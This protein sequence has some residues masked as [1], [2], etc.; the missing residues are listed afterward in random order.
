MQARAGK[1]VEST[2]SLARFECFFLSPV[3]TAA[4]SLGRKPY[5]IGTEIKL[6]PEGATQRRC[7]QICVAPRVLLAPGYRRLAA[8]K[9][10]LQDL[11]VV[12]AFAF[13]RWRY[14]TRRRPVTHPPLPG[15]REVFVI[16]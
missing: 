6:S 11:L 12:R 15:H 8:I 2:R 9:V 1:C 5:A 3:G 10:Q 7:V 13:G 14:S 4:D 16:G